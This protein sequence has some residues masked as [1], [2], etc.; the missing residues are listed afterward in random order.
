MRSQREHELCGVVI[1][2]H[3]SEFAIIRSVSEK[4]VQYVGTVDI[5]EAVAVN[6]AEHHAGLKEALDAVQDIA[7]RRV[8]DS[9]V[10]AH[11]IVECMRAR[12]ARG[13]TQCP[14]QALYFGL[15]HDDPFPRLVGTWLLF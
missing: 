5:C 7:V 11:A 6:S 8:Y 9:I 12:L 4:P 14:P 3:V 13:R 1:G 2:N 10:H 15:V